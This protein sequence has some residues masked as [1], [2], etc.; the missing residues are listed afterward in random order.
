MIFL[1]FPYSYYSYWNDMIISYNPPFVKCKNPQIYSYKT[2]RNMCIFKR[3]LFMMPDADYSPT[4]PAQIV[5]TTKQ[6]PEAP[7]KCSGA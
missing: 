5:V 2:S 1:V 7:Q 4:Y 6:C 3:L